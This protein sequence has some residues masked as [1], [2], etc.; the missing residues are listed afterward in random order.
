VALDMVRCL[1]RRQASGDGQS[2]ALAI[3]LLPH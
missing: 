2:E 1:R 3:Y